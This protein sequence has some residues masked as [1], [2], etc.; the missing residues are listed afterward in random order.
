[1]EIMKSYSLFSASW[2]T[3]KAGN[4]IQSEFTGLR[5][6]GGGWFKSWSESK[7]PRMRSTSVPGQEKMDVAAQAKRGDSPFLCLSVQLRPSLDW[8]MSTRIGDGNLYS[9]C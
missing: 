8:M 9:V 4:T 2:R 6:E 7:S 3:R 1:M 5:I